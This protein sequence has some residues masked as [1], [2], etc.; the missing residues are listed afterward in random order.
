MRVLAQ[1]KRPFLAAELEQAGTVDVRGELFAGACRSEAGVCA[2]QSSLETVESDL[3]GCYGIRMTDGFLGEVLGARVVAEVQGLGCSR[4]CRDG[5]L[6]SQRG[7]PSHSIRGDQLAW[8]QGRKPGRQGPRGSS[9]R[10]GGFGGTLQI[11]PEGRPVVANIEPLFDRLLIFWLDR[12][13]PHEVQPAY[14]A[15]ILQNR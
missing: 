1:K 3:A 9:D 8:V 12:R 4:K 7:L 6:A 13:N 15:R 10:L 5:Q 2:F 11:Y 14:A